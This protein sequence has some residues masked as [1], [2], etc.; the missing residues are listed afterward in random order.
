ML[1][2]STP[3]FFVWA[4][5]DAYTAPLQ[6]VQIIKGYVDASGQPHEQV[7]DVACSDGGVPDLNSF[8]CPNNNA[9]VDISS[10]AF[11]QDVGAV[12]LKTLLQKNKYK[13]LV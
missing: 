10:C 13:R 6:R 12:E 8:R 9:K 4:V 5:R 7:F 11:S 3:S 1:F 2:R